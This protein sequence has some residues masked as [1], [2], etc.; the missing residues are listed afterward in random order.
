MMGKIILII[1]WIKGYDA[2]IEIKISSKVSL[3]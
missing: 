2:S 1:E 3:T